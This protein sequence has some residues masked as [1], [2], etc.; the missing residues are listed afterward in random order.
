MFL[1]NLSFAQKAMAATVTTLGLLAFV[2][3][4]Y[5]RTLCA[6]NDSYSS[7]LMHEVEL[8]R[9]AAQVETE[10]LQ[11]RRREK[12]F[13]LRRDP[14]YIDAVREEQAKMVV[15]AERIGEISREMGYGDI[16]DLAELIVVDADLYLES[17][18]AFSDL[19]VKMGLDH[20]SGLEG[21]FRTAVHAVEDEVR[22]YINDEPYIDLLS[23][24]RWEK[25]FLRTRDEKYSTRFNVSLAEFR[26]GVESGG[27][28]ESVKSEVN[29]SL[30]SYESGWSSIRNGLKSDPNFEYAEL[31]N[32]MRSDIHIC[33]D[34]IKFNYVHGVRGDLLQIRRGEKDYLM[35]HDVKYR[36]RTLAAIDMFVESVES[37]EIHDEQKVLIERKMEDYRVAF[38]KLVN[39][40]ELS[41]TKLAEMR[42]AVHRTQEPIDQILDTISQIIVEHSAT[43]LETAGNSRVLALILTA[44]AVVIGLVLGGIN[45]MGSSKLT[46]Q[47]VIVSS[48]IRGSAEAT[49]VSADQMQKISHSIAENA[50]QQASTLEESSA[51]LDSVSVKTRANADDVLKAKELTGETRESAEAGLDNMKELAEAMDDI[52][53]SSDNI[54]EIIKT[55]DEIAFQ[56]NLLALNASVEAAR[57]GEAG[58]GFSVVADEVRNLALRSAK[59]AKETSSKIEDAIA[60]SERGVQINAQVA[61][62]LGSITNGVRSLDEIIASIAT[63][64][65][66]QSDS[67]DQL[68]LA[69]SG[70][71]ASVHLNA[72][73]A[74]EGAAS[75][76]EMKGQTDTLYDLVQSLGIVIGQHGSKSAKKRVTSVEGT[77]SEVLGGWEMPTDR[78]LGDKKGEA[79]SKNV[80]TAE[81][82]W[83]EF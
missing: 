48:G 78:S 66:D 51:S 6:S 62:R 53:G 7:L 69:V 55:I 17:F 10:M 75:V 21:A 57:A 70:M 18:T 12:D 14:K 27:L 20:N 26:D 50:S 67:I 16:E 80:A 41:K 1:S 61:E 40:N 52:K 47:L 30:A 58:A 56:T 83:D 76:M 42:E 24:R 31:Y 49:A 68:S 46:K 81:V 45:S 23:I 82:V 54:A 4:T 39:A 73:S 22:H 13:I 11:T 15:A 79:K 2:A 74:E 37:S 63:A 60:K 9:L 35:R 71:N 44:I 19:Y 29:K 43:T 8:G 64:S 36:D 5:D 65:S 59:A 32:R 33:E 72:A 3:Y 34:A 28:P 38:L 25:D 77:Q